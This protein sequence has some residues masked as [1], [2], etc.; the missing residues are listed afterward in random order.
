MTITTNSRAIIILRVPKPNKPLAYVEAILPAAQYIGKLINK[1]NGSSAVIYVPALP[2][3]LA[4][5]LLN[6]TK[7]LKVPAV[8]DP[9]YLALASKDDFIGN[10]TVNTETLLPYIGDA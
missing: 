6:H 5:E 9:M 4:D 2:I 7:E 8:D 1:S 10:V 3:T